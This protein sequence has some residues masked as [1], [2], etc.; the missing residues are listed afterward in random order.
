M[1]SQQLSARERRRISSNAFK[2][3][4]KKTHAD[5]VATGETK[6]SEDRRWGATTAGA[7]G[8][9]IGFAEG[10]VATAANVEGR[11]EKS[12]KSQLLACSKWSVYRVKWRGAVQ[13]TKLRLPC[14]NNHHL[15]CSVRRFP[16]QA[17]V[18]FINNGETKGSG[19]SWWIAKV[20]VRKGTMF[21]RRGVIVGR[22]ST[23]VSLSRGYISAVIV[24][25]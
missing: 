20:W 25:R 3:S 11:L 8:Q 2:N 1:A 12:K 17:Q 23:G 21:Q 10:G 9:I 14:S 4:G 13:G 19:A 22:H 15:L 18:N 16:L 5:T 7:K 6:T 24:C